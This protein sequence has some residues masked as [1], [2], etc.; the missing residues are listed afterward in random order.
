MQR[1][2][3]L[4][5]EDGKLLVFERFRHTSQGPR[6]YL[7][8]P[9]GAIEPHET[10]E[11]A[12]VRELQEEMLITVKPLQMVATLH[13]ST[14]KWFHSSEHFFFV[15]TRVSGEPTFSKTSEEAQLGN[16]ERFTPVWRSLDA[17]N[18]NP[19]LH[20]LYEPVVTALLDHLRA[21]TFPKEPLDIQAD[22]LV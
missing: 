3:A 5:V 7:S 21:G 4:I 14:T 13:A 19:P 6:H 8:I 16:G 11:Q 17:L 18:Q 22:D 10:P 2:A 12:V 9:G 15:C 1:A 20:P